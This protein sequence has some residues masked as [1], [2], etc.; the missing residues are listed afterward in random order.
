MWS[1]ERTDEQI[2]RETFK[3]EDTQLRSETKRATERDKNRKENKQGKVRMKREE[4]I[5]NTGIGMIILGE[6]R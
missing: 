5:R 6:F 4:D 1:A 3:H 2:Q